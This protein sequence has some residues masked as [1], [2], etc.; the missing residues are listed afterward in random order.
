MWGV[1]KKSVPPFDDSVTL[2]F[3]L[4]RA[5]GKKEGERKEGKVE[6]KEATRTIHE[7]GASPD[8]PYLVQERMLCLLSP[9]TL[10]SVD[11]T[12]TFAKMSSQNPS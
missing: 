3:G 7:E 4:E 5:E 9:S 2:V 1:A 11:C 8:S 12:T 6:R 10:S